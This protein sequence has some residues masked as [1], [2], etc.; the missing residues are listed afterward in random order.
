MNRRFCLRKYRPSADLEMNE[1]FHRFPVPCPSF[2]PAV[3]LVLACSDL[4]LSC[5]ALIQ[6]SAAR[7]SAKP[8]CMLQNRKLS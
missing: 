2:W 1:G 7:F 6:P 5:R 4:G 8:G 3:T